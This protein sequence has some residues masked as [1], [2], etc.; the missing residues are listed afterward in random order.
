[1]S[2]ALAKIEF[3][4]E[5]LVVIKKQFFPAGGSPAEQQYCFAVAKELGLN[6]ITR[7]IYF[8]PRRQKINNQWVE[9]IEPMVGR[10]GF[11]SIAH[12]SSQLAGM[13]TTANI[14]E[15]PQLVNGRWEYRKDLLAECRVWRKDSDK[16]FAVQVSYSEY[17][18]KNNDGQP[19]R[20]WSE[21]PETMLKKVAES[22]A[23][24]KA[25]NIHGV[26]SP[27]EMGAGFETAGGDLVVSPSI[28][29][30]FSTVP[31]RGKE[32]GPEPAPNEADDGWPPIG[33]TPKQGD[34]PKGEYTLADIAN[35]LA[36][37]S[38]KY[39]LD[40]DCGYIA[41]KSFT[42]KDFLKSIGFRWEPEIKSWVWTGMKEAA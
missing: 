21:K 20:F 26:Y 22:Q 24:R 11:L 14:Q 9:K 4:Q 12:R 36:A 33:P 35:M 37:K 25:F 10:D 42:H 5:E 15:V 31:D 27:E 39:E 6:P 7:E 32:P 23:L 30:E 1:M 38:I 41:A 3:S 18:Q 16:P 34:Q 13:E 29:A 2:N 19:T 8:V 28:E 40:E 17:V